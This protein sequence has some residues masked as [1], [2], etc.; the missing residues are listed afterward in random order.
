MVL[1]MI[2]L[3]LTGTVCALAVLLAVSSLSYF[4][5]RRLI[6]AQSFLHSDHGP[7]IGLSPADDAENRLRVRLVEASDR[8]VMTRTFSK[9][10]GLAGYGL[11]LVGQE[12]L[13][14]DPNSCNIK[15]LQTKRDKL[16]HFLEN[17]GGPDSRQ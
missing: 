17:V 11:E 4:L 7:R 6:V 8:V 5:A 14:S 1:S 3:R 10:H 2:D 13:T 12:P 16:G 15:Y 9:I